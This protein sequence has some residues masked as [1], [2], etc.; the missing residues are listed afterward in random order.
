MKLRLGCS[1]PTG[2]KQTARA[3]AP[4][5]ADKVIRL[6]AKIAGV[7]I[8]TATQAASESL[9][10][11]GRN[12][13]AVNRPIFDFSRRFNLRLA[14]FQL[15]THRKRPLDQRMHRSLRLNESQ[16]HE[17]VVRGNQLNRRIQMQRLSKTSGRDAPLFGGLAQRE[18]I[19]F[20]LYRGA[21]HVSLQSKSNFN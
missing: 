14:L 2:I 15:R 9:S 12:E 21:E 20:R 13:R 11:N 5:N 1:L 16:R 19:A 10:A 7:A 4:A 18:P 6:P 3:D 8:P 17:I